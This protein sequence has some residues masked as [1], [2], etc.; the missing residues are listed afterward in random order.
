MIFFFRKTAS[1]AQIPPVPRKNKNRSQRSDSHS[2]LFGLFSSTNE[3]MISIPITKPI[4]TNADIMM[5]ISTGP[6]PFAIVDPILLSRVLK[7]GDSNN[8]G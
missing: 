8:K 6:V 7:N 4:E 3:V 1:N 2:V 5:K